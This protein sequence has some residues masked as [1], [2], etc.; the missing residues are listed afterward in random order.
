LDSNS[1]TSFLRLK[2][3]LRINSKKWPKYATKVIYGLSIFFFKKVN[4]TIMK[5]F[6]ILSIENVLKQHPK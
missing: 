2:F 1:K 4:N 5:E 6:A 3:T